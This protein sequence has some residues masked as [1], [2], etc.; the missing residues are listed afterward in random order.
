VGGLQSI[1]RDANGPD[2]RVEGAVEMFLVEEGSVGDE[3]DA[4]S[5]SGEVVTQLVPIRTQERFAAGDVD[6]LTTE[7]H[8]IPRDGVEPFR[9]K[10]AARRLPAL[11]FT[12]DTAQVALACDLPDAG[13]RLA[14]HTIEWV[15][16]QTKRTPT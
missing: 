10:L 8:Q 9:R 7:S 6:M 16:F 14:R 3:G 12:V 2:A 1:E 5:K 13:V 11:V 15:S 4:Q